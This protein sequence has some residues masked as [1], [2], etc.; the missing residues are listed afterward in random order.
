MKNKM[1]TFTLGD[2][3]INILQFNISKIKKQG[4]LESFFQIFGMARKCLKP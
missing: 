4:M 2:V 3:K 1:G